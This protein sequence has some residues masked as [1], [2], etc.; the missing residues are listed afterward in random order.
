MGAVDDASLH[1]SWSVA[2]DPAA[3]TLVND[4]LDRGVV[5]DP[6]PAGGNDDDLAGTL[7]Y[8]RP[9]GGSV[10]LDFQMEGLRC[11]FRQPRPARRHQGL[12]LHWCSRVQSCLGVAVFRRR[13]AP[14]AH[15]AFGWCDN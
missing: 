12:P 15:H 1:M 6:F 2:G 14:A 11:K 5:I 13:E 3:K 10:T 9:D 4:D 8:T 7:V